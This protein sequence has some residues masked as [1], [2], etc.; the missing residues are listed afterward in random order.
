[1]RDPLRSTYRSVG[2]VSY[3]SAPGA[4]AVFGCAV[5]HR[6]G[7][8]WSRQA[9]TAMVFPVLPVVSFGAKTT[10]VDPHF[11]LQISKARVCAREHVLVQYV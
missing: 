9:N 7:G 3:I 2:G 10:T 6:G 8:D 4:V 1:M 5:L 11:T